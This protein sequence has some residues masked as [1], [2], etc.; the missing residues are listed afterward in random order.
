MNINHR[1]LYQRHIIFDTVIGL[2]LFVAGNFNFANCIVAVGCAALVW[3]SAFIRTGSVLA[4]YNFHSFV[5]HDLAA[6][7]FVLIHLKTSFFL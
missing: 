2:K 7:S 4:L 1:T 6:S 5:Y 3:F